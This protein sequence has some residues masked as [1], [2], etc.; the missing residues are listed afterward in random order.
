MMMTRG[1][2]KKSIIHLADGTESMDD[3]GWSKEG[4][5]HVTRHIYTTLWNARTVP[6]LPTKKL[7]KLLTIRF[8]LCCIVVAAYY[9]KAGF[10]C[11]CCFFFFFFFLFKKKQQEKWLLL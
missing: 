11:C 6:L 3:K 8:M 9:K 4:G 7:M 2:Q 5:N 10:C 1:Q